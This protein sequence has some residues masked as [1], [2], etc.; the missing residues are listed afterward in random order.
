VFGEL[1]G[2]TPPADPE[3]ASAPAGAD[4]SR[5]AGRYERMSRRYDIFGRAGGLRGVFETTGQLAA[6][7]ESAA[8]ELDLYPSDA[9]GDN[10]VCRSHEDE[11]WTSVSFGMLA[12]G[13]AYLYSGGRVTRRVGSAARAGSGVGSGGV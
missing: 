2:V 4:Y 9:S 3:P 11:A 10:F 12:D 1:C 6:S 13:T 7:R 5:H 8:E